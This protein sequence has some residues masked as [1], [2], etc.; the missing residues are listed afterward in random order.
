MAF[1]QEGI[2]R[3]AEVHRYCWD[4]WIKE[5]CLL[6][7][8]Y[9]NH[10]LT[11]GVAH[12]QDAA[13][14]EEYA[15]MHLFSGIPALFSWKLPTFASAYLWLIAKQ[16]SFT[17]PHLLNSRG[18]GLHRWWGR[19][20]KSLSASRLNSC[21]VERI[22]AVNAHLNASNIFK[23][24]LDVRQGP[25]EMHNSWRRNTPQPVQRIMRGWL[26]QQSHLLLE[27]VSSYLQS[28]KKPQDRL[29]HSLSLAGWTLVYQ[30]CT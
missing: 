4:Y 3:W 2:F 21:E 6:S 29:S 17:I 10:L 5:K 8:S 16:A 1:L 15:C 11:L 13:F 9:K 26:Q 27:K 28:H 14:S 20:A 7:E 24:T 23:K 30:S 18:L 19:E 22:L 12:H 25:F